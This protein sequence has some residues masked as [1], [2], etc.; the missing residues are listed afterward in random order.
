M[1]PHTKQN[2]S[3]PTPLLTRFHYLIATG[4]GSGR[5]PCA[6]GTFGTL[7]AVF[8]WI[9]VHRIVPSLSTET[10]I[11]LIIALFFI[12]TRSTHM[13]I[14]DIQNASPPVPSLPAQEIDPGFVVI[15]E[16]V[17]VLIAL[18]AASPSNLYSIVGAFALFRL[19]DILKPGPID[20]AQRAPGAWGVMLDD[21]LAG[22]ASYAILV[23]AL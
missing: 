3:G 20:W 17:G 19:F 14:R 18:I 5:I 21:V 12:G 6:P 1:T 8:T 2:N 7:A 10:E 13:V 22:L 11:F 15:D 4:L 9:L 16:W 23:L